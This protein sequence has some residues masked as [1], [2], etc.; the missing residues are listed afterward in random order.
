MLPVCLRSW[1]CRPGAPTAATD[2]AHLTS[3][4]NVPRYT[5]RPLSP[6]K[7]N[8]CQIRTVGDHDAAADHQGGR[9]ARFEDDAAAGR[10]RG[11]RRS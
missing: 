8:A 10:D 3:L 9:A 4:L 5:V 1:K 6:V 11:T 7:T 2:S